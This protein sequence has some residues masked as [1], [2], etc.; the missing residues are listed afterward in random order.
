MDYIT[1]TWLRQVLNSDHH[2]MC[3]VDAHSDHEPAIVAVVEVWALPYSSTWH[4]ANSGEYGQGQ[5]QQ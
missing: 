5:Y 2:L 3:D 4:L 1:D